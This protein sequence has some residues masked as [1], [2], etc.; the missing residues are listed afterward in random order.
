MKSLTRLTVQTPDSLTAKTIGYF[1]NH[2]LVQHARNDWRSAGFVR[3]SQSRPELWS[4]NLEQVD[5]GD[6][7]RVDFLFMPRVGSSDRTEELGSRV[8]LWLHRGAASVEVE[9]FLVN[10]WR[11]PDSTEAGPEEAAG[12][13]FVLCVKAPVAS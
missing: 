6:G 4:D 11:R 7:D 10:K 5:V 2:S 13:L 12:A 9:R 1:L 3:E 8:A